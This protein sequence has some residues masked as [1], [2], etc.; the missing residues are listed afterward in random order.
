MTETSSD[1]EAVEESARDARDGGNERNERNERN[2]RNGAEALGPLPFLRNRP[3]QLITAAYAAVWIWMAIEPKYPSDWLLENLLVFA[4]VGLLA[5]TYRRFQFSN[6]SYALFALFLALHAY[7]AHSTYSETPFGFWLQQT[8]DLSRNPYDRIVHFAFGLLLTYPMRELGLRRMHLRGAYS[9]TVPFLVIL[10]LSADYELVESW[11]A[12]FVSPE[13]GDAY[14]GTQGDIWD[15]QKD[16]NAA[17]VGSLLAL[18]FAWGWGKVT[19]R[20]AWRG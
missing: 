16:M 4:F 12:R 17:Q 8:F 18:V 15:A 9:W 1:L 5:A 20:E 14:L 11:V 6:L 10:A 3:L 13:L 2:G 7:G 19:G